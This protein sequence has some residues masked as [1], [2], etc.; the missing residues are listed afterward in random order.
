[1]D[2]LVDRAIGTAYLFNPGPI[3]RDR[4]RSSGSWD[5]YGE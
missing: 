1:V 2:R 5:R 3:Q 4:T